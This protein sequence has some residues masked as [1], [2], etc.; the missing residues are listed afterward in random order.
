MQE[1]KKWSKQKN[2]RI[3]ELE[4]WMFFLEGFLELGTQNFTSFV[5]C[6]NYFKFW[7]S[8]GTRIQRQA[9][10]HD[11]LPRSRLLGD[12]DT[13]SVIVY[14]EEK[15]VLYWVDQSSKGR[16]KI[17]CTGTTRP[18]K[19]PR[20]DPIHLYSMHKSSF[21]LVSTA[22]RG[23]PLSGLSGYKKSRFLSGSEFRK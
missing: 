7:L 1:E 10:L 12:G 23:P 13:P 6:K 11:C 20:K 9:A 14:G 21:A 18:T 5:N 15:H 2:L 16:I 3:G 19:M 8:T 22:S 4:G 17:S